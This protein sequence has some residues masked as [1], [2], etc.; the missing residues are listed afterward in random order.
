MR[1]SLSEVSFEE[2]K[3]KSFEVIRITELLCELCEKPLREK[4]KSL[5]KIYFSNPQEYVD[6][7]IR[8]KIHDRSEI[9]MEVRRIYFYDH[10]FP[11]DIHPSCVE[12]L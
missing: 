2:V 4:E 11:G 12:K 8:S 6:L 1:K 10:D 7:M 9:D 3:G 5:K